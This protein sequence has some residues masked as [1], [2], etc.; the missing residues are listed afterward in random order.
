MKNPKQLS[1]L[2]TLTKSSNILIDNFTVGTME[3]LGL[4]KEELSN[5]NSSL[6]QLSMSG[7]GKGSSVEN[8]RSY[9]LVLSALSGAELSITKEDNLSDLQHFL[10]VIPTRPYLQ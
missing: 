3:R 8:L 7:P 10:L 1:V 9:G 2:K 6:V 4:G 5:L